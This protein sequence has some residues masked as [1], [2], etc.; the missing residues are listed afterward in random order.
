MTSPRKHSPAVSSV[1]AVTTRVRFPFSC[2]ST[3]MFLGALLLLLL[4]LVAWGAVGGSCPAACRTLCGLKS[5]TTSSSCASIAQRCPMGSLHRRQY[6]T[7]RH[8]VP[9]GPQLSHGTRCSTVP[10]ALTSAAAAEA[11]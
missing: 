9:D 10:A 2:R 11:E 6:G 7:S 3:L 5:R 8:R 4:L 1:G